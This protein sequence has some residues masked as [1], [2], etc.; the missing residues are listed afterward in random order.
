MPRHRESGYSSSS[1]HSRKRPKP[2]YTI[3]MFPPCVGYPEP[4]P[5]YPT[6]VPQFDLSPLN[7][8]PPRHSRSKSP[9]IQHNPERSHPSTATSSRDPLRRKRSFAEYYD[10]YTKRENEHPGRLRN[11]YR[12]R[13]RQM[14]RYN[15]DYAQELTYDGVFFSSYDQAKGAAHMAKI[16]EEG[17]GSKRARRNHVERKHIPPRGKTL[18]RMKSF[19][20][21]KDPY[22]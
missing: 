18:R 19:F 5:Y 17:H 15:E 20:W 11:L 10:H 7:H 14:S 22:W 9:P 4:K 16:R 13:E 12:R 2:K 3:D 6:S 1:G 8:Q 21:G